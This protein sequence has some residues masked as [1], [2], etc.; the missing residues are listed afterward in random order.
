RGEGRR[1]ARATNPSSPGAIF[2]LMLTGQPPVS[3]GDTATILTQVREGTVTPPSQQRQ[4]PTPEIDG[5]ILKAMEKNS[6]RRPL[7][8]RQFLAEVAGV[9]G[10]P[11]AAQTAPA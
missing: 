9:V 5:V 3:G 6:S 8:M 1:A 7:T 2:L 11:A 4:G 10:M